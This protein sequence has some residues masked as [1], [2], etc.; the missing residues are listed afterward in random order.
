MNAFGRQLA[1]AMGPGSSAWDDEAFSAELQRALAE[2]S[3][4]DAD[5]DGVDNG[6]E[7]E[8]GTVP[9]DGSSRPVDAACSDIEAR[10]SLRYDTCGYDPRYAL[11][12]VHLDVCGTLPSLERSRS[13]AE[14]DDP[15]AL[16]LETLE[17]CLRSEYWRGRDGVLWNLANER[18]GPDASTKSGADAGDIPLADYEDDYNLFVYT[19]IDGHDA[20]EVLTADYFVSRDD[21]EPTT[22]E[23]YVRSILDDLDMRGPE[24][25]QFVGQ[26]RR[27]GMLT[28]RWFLTNFVM[29]TA[30]PRTAAAQ[31]YRAYLGYDIAKM[32]GLIAVDAEPADYDAKGVAAPQCAG[33]HSTLDPLTYPFSRYEGLGGGDGNDEDLI[34]GAYNPSRL[35][36]FITTDGPGVLDMPES[37]WLF[38][39]EVRDL[40]QWAAVAVASDDFA[41]ATVAEYWAYFLGEPPRP[42]ES[43]EFDDLWRRF[44]TTHGY[45]IDAMLHDLVMTEAYGVP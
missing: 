29:F 22:Y 16:V 28:T 26:S 11:R 44:S 45:S 6:D 18:I 5:E 10:A 2:I 39:Q 31:A 21:T 43:A 32:E 8:A 40:R 15:R 19:Q 1:D 30:I 4:L 41:R 24:V 12:K 17:T 9:S 37:G 38:G 33:C 36:R 35:Q 3:E 7:I 27:A 23:P 42:D 25:A 13:L 34:P 20:R 14:S